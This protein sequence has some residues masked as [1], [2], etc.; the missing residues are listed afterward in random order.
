MSRQAEGVQVED[1]VF[2]LVLVGAVLLAAAPF[3]LWKAVE[4]TPSHYQTLQLKDLLKGALTGFGVALSL[5]LGLWVFPAFGKSPL[6]QLGHFRLELGMI[7]SWFILNLFLGSFA[8]L[9]LPFWRG[10]VRSK[11]QMKDQ[12]Y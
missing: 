8:Y 1:W 6:L 7:L 3:L 12:L 9:T 2:T 4:V 10:W 5:S 11:S